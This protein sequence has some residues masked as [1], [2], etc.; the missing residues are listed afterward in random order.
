MT[1]AQG[2]GRRRPAAFGPYLQVAP[3]A[4]VYAVFLGVPLL[5]LVVVSFFD[6]DS[7]QIIPGF[8]L[9]NYQD[10]LISATTWRTYLST[11]RFAFVVWATTLF[12]AFWIAYYLAFH[13]RSRVTRMALFLFCT[14]PFL[15][16]NIIRMI[17]WVPFLGRN[18][19]LNQSLV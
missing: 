1:G 15:T 14:I 3:L 11:I 16:S 10:V 12:I 7:V 18:G 6:Y 13:L 5:T 8:V 2:G 4:L 17:S 9:T 19:L